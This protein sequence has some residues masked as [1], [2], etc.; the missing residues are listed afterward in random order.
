MEEI[1]DWER[2]LVSGLVGGL[3][4]YFIVR[5][6]KPSAEVEGEVKDVTYPKFF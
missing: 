4:V 5:Y 6:T 3:A 2:P 1:L